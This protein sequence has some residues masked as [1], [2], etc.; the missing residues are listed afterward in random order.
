M[1]I[2]TIVSETRTQAR[3]DAFMQGFFRTET[4]A[5]LTFTIARNKNKGATTNSTIGLRARR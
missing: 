4:I 1:Q 5:L 2:H 3:R